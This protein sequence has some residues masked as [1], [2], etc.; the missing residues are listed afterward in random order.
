[1]LADQPTGPNNLQH[2]PFLQ[3]WE[4]D[5]TSTAGAAL[6]S[7]GLACVGADAALNI[8]GEY[9][10]IG[11]GVVAVSGLI[12]I[13]IDDIEL[14]INETPNG[15]VINK[16]LA[17]T[18]A[19]GG[20]QCFPESWKEGESSLSTNRLVD[21]SWPVHS[22]NTTSVTIK[23]EYRSLV[24]DAVYELTF[25]LKKT[26]EKRGQANFTCRKINIIQIKLPY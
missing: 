19:R 8:C 24:N 16:E 7:I 23:K 21:V 14:F 13:L 22:G 12:L 1:M 10:L 2:T 15:L 6:L 20:F 17:S 11:C 5:A 3:L 18:M 26:G 4:N 9:C 25:E